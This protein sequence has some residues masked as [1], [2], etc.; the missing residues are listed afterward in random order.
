MT[1]GTATV[2]RTNVRGTTARS[3]SAWPRL[4]LRTTRVGN[5]ASQII[6]AS[7]CLDGGGTGTDMG[8]FLQLDARG[9]DRKTRT[10]SAT[11]SSTRSA[12]IAMAAAEPSPAAVITWARGLAM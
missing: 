6:R 4:R 7:W 2:A 10:A 12:L 5:T 3:A 9:A 11:S 8:T 1:I